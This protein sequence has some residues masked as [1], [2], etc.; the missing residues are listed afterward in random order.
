MRRI[1]SLH[2][3]SSKR[4]YDVRVASVRQGREESDSTSYLPSPPLRVGFPGIGLP[5]EQDEGERRGLR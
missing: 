4:D 2:G 5:R 1:L 3:L